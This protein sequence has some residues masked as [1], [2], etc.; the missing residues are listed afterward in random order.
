MSNT[1]TLSLSVLRTL[2]EGIDRLNDGDDRDRQAADETR[3]VLAQAGYVVENGQTY[4]AT[5]T[6]DGY[7]AGGTHVFITAAGHWSKRV[8]PGSTLFLDEEC[9]VPLR[10]V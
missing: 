2:A 5:E 8:K 1:I 9:T 4:P 7:I 6:T 10:T 3:K